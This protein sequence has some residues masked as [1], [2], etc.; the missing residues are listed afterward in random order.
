MKKYLKIWVTALFVTLIVCALY[1]TAASYVVENWV[2]QNGG[3]LIPAQYLTHFADLTEKRFSG[4]LE[5]IEG[6]SIAATSEDLW[7]TYYQVVNDMSSPAYF[8][9]SDGGLALMKNG[10]VS[11]YDLA[12][13]IW[14]ADKD[15]NIV[16]P[17]DYTV[18][19]QGNRRVMA[20]MRSCFSEEEMR[21]LTQLKYEVDVPPFKQHTILMREYVIKDGICYPLM[22]TV[23]K[24]NGEEISYEGSPAF[25]IT[26]YEHVKDAAYVWMDNLQRFDNP[27]YQEIKQY[28]KN[29]LAAHSAGQ[30]YDSMQT[31]ITQWGKRKDK[32][33]K[34]TEYV[35]NDGEYL[36][37][38]GEISNYGRF[39]RTVTFLGWGVICVIALLL[40]AMI[41]FFRQKKYQKAEYERAVTN[42]LAHDYKSSLMIQRGY[43]ENLL[44]GVSEEKKHLYEQK[45]MD[46]IDKMDLR[47]ERLLSMFR[48]SAGGSLETEEEIDVEGLC[49]K[50]V[51]NYEELSRKRG[52]T[53]SFGEQKSPE[54]KSPEQGTSKGRGAFCIKA[55]RVLLSMALDNLIN[56]ACKYSL[57]DSE[58]LLDFTRDSFSIRNRWQPVEKF[59]K[60]PKL[61]W[62]P[63][64]TGSDARTSRNSG[65][66]LFAA[67]QILKRMGFVLSVKA[68]KEKV[69]F[70]VKRRGKRSKTF[71]TVLLLL[72]IALAGCGRERIPAAE[73]EVV[74]LIHYE[75]D[76]TD[77]IFMMT[78]VPI[79]STGCACEPQY[80]KKVIS[81]NYS[82]RA[83][84]VKAENSDGS[85]YVFQY[86]LEGQTKLLING[87]EVWNAEKSTA[88]IDVPAYVT[89]LLGTNAELEAR[90]AT[91]RVSATYDASEGKVDIWDSVG[92]TA[93][94][95]LDGNLLYQREDSIKDDA[96]WNK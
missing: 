75:Y 53:W 96:Y 3:D 41:T 74:K 56:N 89:Q 27:D 9:M 34:V 55:D 45:I 79:Y 82:R 15:G 38:K 62:E 4:T 67:Q 78:K 92:L 68:D 76:G 28:T 47:T 44:Y 40:T 54:Q 1:R 20:D 32:Y 81:V 95:D 46:E 30:K 22:I 80:G 66:G 84:G 39:L 8:L 86:D 83:D 33:L 85:G 70:M 7:I 36:L 23:T 25:D 58:I 12:R 31:G 48:A 71:L 10:G 37:C 63:Y 59:I 90:G 21:E 24:E 14:I 52:L 94:Y 51:T 50:L 93:S 91:E 60:H 61:F 11:V 6:N 19:Y 87:K 77:G 69:C 35:L 29:V 57:Q 88:S 17:G 72:M 13:V 18:F 26:G 65:I 49:R 16:L 73:I 42:A 2:I 43:A 64:V 5:E